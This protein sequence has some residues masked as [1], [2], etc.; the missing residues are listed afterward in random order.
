MVKYIKKY[1]KLAPGAIR[2]R[3]IP[4]SHGNPQNAYINMPLKMTGPFE[5]QTFYCAKLY[6]G[7]RDLNPRQ[8]PGISN[9]NY[10]LLALIPCTS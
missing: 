4:K 6:S 9:E 5:I 8:I 3:F 2:S 1:L 7:Y 10:E